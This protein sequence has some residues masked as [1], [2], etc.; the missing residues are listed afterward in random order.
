[1]KLCL[2]TAVFPPHTVGGYELGCRDI[3]RALVAQGHDVHVLTSASVGRLR[4]SAGAPDLQVHEIFDPVFG[5]EAELVAQLGGSTTWTH[6]WTECLS[7]V[8]YGNALALGRWLETHRPD[9]VWLFGTIGL[10]PVGIYEAALS[11]NARV[12]TL[13]MDDIDGYVLGSRR[14]L[15]WRPRFKRLKSRIDA[16]SCSELT[17]TANRQIGDYRRHSVI[18]NGAPFPAR[19]PEAA[20][21]GSVFSFCYH[22]QIA[23]HKGLLHVVRAAAVLRQQRPDLAFE[24]HLYGAGTRLF[25]HRL[26]GEIRDAG[27]TGQFTL[28]GFVEKDELMH[29]LRHHDAALHL[30]RSGEP[31]AY[32]P[33]EAAVCGL[34][35]LLSRTGG[36][37]EC[38]RTDYPLL[39]EDRDDAGAVARLMAWCLEHRDQLPALATHIYD[40]FQANC[41]FGRVTLPA[42][43]DA[44]EQTPPNACPTSIASLLASCRSVDFYAQSRLSFERLR[45]AALSEAPPVAW[46]PATPPSQTALVKP[47]PIL[48][49]HLHY[50]LEEADVTRLWTLPLDR[51]LRRVLA[52]AVA[53]QQAAWTCELPDASSLARVVVIKSGRMDLLARLL[54]R[55]VGTRPHAMIHVLCHEKDVT[56]VKEL[57]PTADVRPVAYPQFGP[58]GAAILEETL[59]EHVPEHVSTAFYLDNS[60]TGRGADLEHVAAALLARGFER[61]YLFNWSGALHDQRIVRWPDELMAAAPVFLRWWGALLAE[62]GSEKITTGNVWTQSCEHQPAG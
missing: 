57:R 21:G 43:L 26:V 46:M 31:F 35:M 2:I 18:Y 52:Q 56:A 41:D 60:P 40:D 5:H 33:I 1:V 36:N 34:P 22:G 54:D 44:I 45:A 32:A 3:A 7:G 49:R 4:K 53:D 12:L 24:I 51:A 37:G 27:L 47:V 25:E 48:P 38:V 58:Y 29:R 55:I 19:R 61:V 8:H 42:Y 10:G 30:L 15:S 59:R 62:H 28:H 20:R 39:V 16:I 17:R 14:N 50:L 11:T 13:L 9:V 23:E 6:E